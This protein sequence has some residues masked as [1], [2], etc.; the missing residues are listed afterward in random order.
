[1]WVLIYYI[2]FIKKNNLEKL[3][4]IKLLNQLLLL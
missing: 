1:M 3:K 2:C 4:N